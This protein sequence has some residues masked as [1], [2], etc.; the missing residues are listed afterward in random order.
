MQL[1]DEG[2]ISACHVWTRQRCRRPCCPL[3]CGHLGSH[4]SVLGVTDSLSLLLKHIFQRPAQNHPPPCFR[5]FEGSQPQWLK[6]LA[7]KS[8]FQ[9]KECSFPQ[10]T[11]MRQ[12]SIVSNNAVNKNPKQI[13]EQVLGNVL[14]KSPQRRIS[15]SE[16]MYFEY[17]GELILTC[18]SLRF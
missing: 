6:S 13:S 10:A 1:R 18:H 14:W 8:I 11:R 3:F 4:H 2:K 17:F 9:V 12:N 15:G 16:Y 5:L 7:H